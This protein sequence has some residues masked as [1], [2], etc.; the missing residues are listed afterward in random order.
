MTVDCMS[1]LVQVSRGLSTNGAVI[2]RDE[3]THASH[4]WWGARSVVACT[5]LHTTLNGVDHWFVVDGTIRL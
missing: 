1:C 3:V 5:M 4:L 2:D